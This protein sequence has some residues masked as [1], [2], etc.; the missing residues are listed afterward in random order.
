MTFN[1]PAMAV[2]QEGCKPAQWQSKDVPFLTGSLHRKS[3]LYMGGQA[4][5]SSSGTETNEVIYRLAT[6]ARIW[7]C[8]GT[9]GPEALPGDKMWV[10]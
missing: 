3:E 7:P 4:V 9:C 2:V 5:R 8:L 1:T 6:A 10:L